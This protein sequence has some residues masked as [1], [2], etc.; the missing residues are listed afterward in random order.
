MTPELYINVAIW[1][2]VFCVYLSLLGIIQGLTMLFC[3]SVVY[4]FIVVLAVDGLSVELIMATF[5]YY[6]FLP[7]VHHFY[8]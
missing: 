7:A 3:K 2:V 1:Y 8:S 4:C 6:C 5:L